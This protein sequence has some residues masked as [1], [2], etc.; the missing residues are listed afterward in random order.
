MVLTNALILSIPRD[1]IRR[2]F[3]T[4]VNATEI[5]TTVRCKTA[6]MNARYFAVRRIWIREMHTI[7]GIAMI[8]RV[9]GIDANHNCFMKTQSHV[10]KIQSHVM[11]VVV[12][13]AV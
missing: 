1:A 7:G 9:R 13:P 3:V 8:F 12:Q 4:L 11:M 6:D 10:S 5:G 2:Y